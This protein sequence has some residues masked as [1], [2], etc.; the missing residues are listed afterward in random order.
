MA[1]AMTG[2]QPNP[3]PRATR[4]EVEQRV[5]EARAMLRLGFSNGEIKSR[6][7]DKHGIKKRSAMRYIT[8]ARKRNLALL[9][10]TED[11]ALSDSL[12]GWRAILHDE[13]GRTQR[14][15][16]QLAE[17]EARLARLD[18]LLAG[19]LSDRQRLGLAE[20]KSA[21]AKLIDNAR[22]TIYTSRKFEME[23]RDRMDRLLGLHRPHKFAQTTSDGR[24][25]HQAAEDVP[26]PVDDDAERREL[27][28]LMASLRARSVPVGEP[29]ENGDNSSKKRL[30]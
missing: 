27:E 16:Q 5:E 2:S 1:I 22:R 3:A 18:E 21:C 13:T 6:L 12:N 15:M 10:K 8:E 7:A 17:Q 20:E 9:D 11:E 24:D 19:E 30:P 4:T 28:E 26:E 29:A 25:V 23:V 14:A